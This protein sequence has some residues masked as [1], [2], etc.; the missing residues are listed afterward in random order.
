MNDEK[1]VSA[2]LPAGLKDVLPP[3]AA[4][5]AHA[6][7][8]LMRVFAGYG[9]ERV[10]P[11]L[12]EFEDTLLAGAGA[13]LAHKTF[14]LMDPASQRMLALRPDMTMQIARIASLRLGHRP[15]PLRLSYAGQ[16]VRVS[17]S[18][19]HAERQFSQV[20]AEIVGEHRTA[21]DVEII[22]MAVEAL[23]ALGITGISIDLGLPTLVAAI[24][25]NRHIA[26]SVLVRLA[27][28]LDRKDVSEV[29]A[30]SPSL[31]TETSA[32]L[33]DL[34]STIGPADAALKVLHK[35]PLSPPA[36]RLR[37]DLVAIVDGLERVNSAFT[38]TVD[39]VESRGFEYHSGVT[40]TVF[41]RGVIGEL[42]R[43]G[44]Y[45]TD[46]KE[47]AT[48]F[49]LFMDSVMRAVPAPP[50]ERR[51]LL[52]PG[53]AAGVARQWRA[54]GWITIAGM[55]DHTAPDQE[56]V[57]LGCSHVLIDGAARET[58][59]NAKRTKPTGDS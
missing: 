58:A 22:T 50:P 34:L 5:E 12:L 57:R 29:K 14:R 32:L 41:A 17:G 9:Y 19:L 21:A 37:E 46:A 6:T 3:D 20:G 31:G 39:C 40:F 16:V 42:G 27:T 10:K 36:A 7:E 44:R 25:E 48:G 26:Q 54:D 23:T 13:A 15:R 59:I 11:P 55:D 45:Q 53:T 1:A 4:F 51:L 38:V 33:A 2:L 52:P 24:L 8:R 18:Q 30:L 43:G 28:A 56:S 47:N 49:S 35:A